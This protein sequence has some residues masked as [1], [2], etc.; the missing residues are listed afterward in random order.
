MSIAIKGRKTL[1]IKGPRPDV[2]VVD[3]MSSAS[4]LV[5]DVGIFVVAWYLRE[6]HPKFAGQH[7]KVQLGRQTESCAVYHHPRVWHPCIVPA[8]G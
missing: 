4:R 7:S 3:V 5:K 6:P 2:W 8:F 1:F